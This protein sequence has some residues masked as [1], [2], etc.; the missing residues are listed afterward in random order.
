MPSGGRRAARRHPISQTVDSPS[1]PREERGGERRPLAPNSRAVHGEPGPAG[2]AFRPSSRARKG[3]PLPGPT[4]IELRN[5]SQSAIPSPSPRRTGKGLG[6]GVSLVLARPSSPRPSPP[7]AGGEG[8]A[9]ASCAGTS[10]IQR[11][12]SPGERESLLAS[13]ESSFVRSEEQSELQ[14]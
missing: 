3:T 5:D 7:L 6:R 13:L 1:P 14:S 2:Q 9:A 11:Q 8:E 4:A 10:L 12:W